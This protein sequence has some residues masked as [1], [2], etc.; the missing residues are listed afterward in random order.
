MTSRRVI[1]T[2][3]EGICKERGSEGKKGKRKKE[4][5]KKEGSEASW[6]NNNGKVELGLYGN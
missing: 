1:G 6:D 4:K 3:N 2:G 5:K